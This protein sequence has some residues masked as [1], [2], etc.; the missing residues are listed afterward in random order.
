MRIPTCRY[1]TGTH[2]CRDMNRHACMRGHT[3]TVMLAWVCT[4]LQMHKH[5]CRGLSKHAHSGVYI[6]RGCTTMHTLLPPAASSSSNWLTGTKFPPAS[7]FTHT[8]WATSPPALSSF[9]G[10]DLPSQ[11]FLPLGTPTPLQRAPCGS[12]PNWQHGAWAV[13]QEPRW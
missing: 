11:E 7:C 12:C 3:C 9:K 1:R 4:C 2:T 5:T 8:V 13:G 6:C 10:R